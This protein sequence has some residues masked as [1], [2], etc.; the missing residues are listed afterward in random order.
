MKG[1]KIKNS[2]YCL[3]IEYV[4]GEVS[5]SGYFGRTS[6]SKHFFISFLVK[7]PPA[8]KFPGWNISATLSSGVLF[9]LVLFLLFLIF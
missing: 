1:R 5:T 8:V 2:R 9:Y 6:K 3:P 7:T 4:A